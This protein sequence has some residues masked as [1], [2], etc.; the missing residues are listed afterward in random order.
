MGKEV[1]W[2]ATPAV[3]MPFIL[4]RLTSMRRASWLLLAA[5]SLSAE[6]AKGYGLVDDIVEGEAELIAEVRKL[7]ERL[8]SCAPGAIAATKQV[9]LTTAG[10]PL[11]SSLFD[12]AA[13]V[14]IEARKNPEAAAGLEA[15]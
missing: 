7:A 12:Y 4:R 8:S 2:G 5:G 10:A 9:A 3:S 14:L 13:S 6:V 1:T 11:T 15:I